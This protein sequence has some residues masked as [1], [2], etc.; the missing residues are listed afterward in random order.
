MVL[1]GSRKKLQNLV[2]SAVQQGA[3]VLNSGSHTDDENATAFPNTIVRDLTDKMDLYHLE[4]FGPLASIITVD[5]EEEAIRVANDTEYGL[6]S[7]V[8]T[9]DLGRAL[10][11]ARK[12]ECG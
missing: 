8:W 5:T 6:N 10:R 12:I 3:T 4:S 2:D 9:R 1:P 11:I 7:A